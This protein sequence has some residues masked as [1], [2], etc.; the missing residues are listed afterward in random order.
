MVP[1]DPYDVGC[2]VKGPAP[3]SLIL[4]SE[5]ERPAIRSEGKLVKEP[6]TG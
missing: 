4:A 3:E 6:S 1:E 5:Q 2:V